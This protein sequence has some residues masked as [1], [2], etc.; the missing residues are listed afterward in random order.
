MDSGHGGAT[1]RRGI[2]LME[3]VGSR[4]S[5]RVL[6]ILGILACAALWGSSAPMV[7]QLIDTFPPCTLAALRLGI[8]VAVLLPVLLVQRRRPRFNREAVALGLSGVAAFQLLQN[9]GMERMPAGTAVVTVLGASV[10]LSALLGWVVLGERCSMP[11][12][13]AMTGCGIGV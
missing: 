13:L 12:M 6:A 9:F 8:A 4:P 2:A 11:M 1:K 10:V 7:K 5:N 3:L